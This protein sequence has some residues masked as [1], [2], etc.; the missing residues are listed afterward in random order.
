SQRP[1]VVLGVSESHAEE[2][3]RL[4]TNLRFL[5]VDTE[6][7]CL[8]I[9]SAMPGEGKTTASVNLAVALAEADMR[10]LLVDADMRRPRIADYMGLENNAGLTTVLIG[11]ATV[12]DVIQPWGGQRL[13]VLTAGEIP[14]NPSELVATRALRDLLEDVRAR[15][16]VV[17]IDAPP[18]LPVA[19]AAIL[20]RMVSGV[21]V[22]AD[23][24]KLRRHQ[25]REV[26]DGV[27]AAGGQVLGVVL[28]KVKVRR[29][30]T[31]GYSS[32]EIAGQR[33]DAEPGEGGESPAL[34]VVA[35]VTSEPITP[36]WP[37]VGVTAS[38]DAT[39]DA[40]GEV[41]AS[42]VDGPAELVAPRPD[43]EQLEV[44]A[45]IAADVRETSSAVADG[46]VDRA[47]APVA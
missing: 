30:S 38:S 18:L 15:Y 26:V 6:G 19:D 7:L 45:A 4:R 27:H 35:G 22:V 28:N 32:H 41:S 31:Y 44:G 33:H 11:R 14:P 13:D 34:Q 36:V 8:V 20:S 47:A 42:S 12:D 24:K 23:T 9:S 2:F 25:L 39:S 3:R 10:V 29:A 46:D 16:D 43:Q 1:A 21:V 17:I 5:S 37:A 40:R